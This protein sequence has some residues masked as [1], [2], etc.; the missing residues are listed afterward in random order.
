MSLD[1]FRPR[2]R[3]P[4]YIYLG[5]AITLVLIGLIMISS[6]SVVIAVET[7]NQTY[8]FVM[9][10]LIAIGV[11][12]VGAILASRISYQRWHQLTLPF[13]IGSLILVLLLLVPGLGKET[14]GAVRWIN[15][16]LFQLQP[17]ELLKISTI[18]YVSAWLERRINVIRQFDTLLGFA[19]F[20]MPIVIVMMIQ[21]DLGTLLI[22]LLTVGVMYF[23]AGAS[24]TQIVTGSVVGLCLVGMLIIIEPYRLERL[25]TFRN[26]GSD[27]LGAGYHINQAN[28]AIGSG[29]W[30]GRGF[31]QSIQKY[32]YLPEPQTDSIFAITV[33]EL[34]FLRSTLILVIIGAFSY[35][36]YQIAH[37]AGETFARFLAFGLTSMFLLQSIINLAAILGIVP[38]TGVP[39][40]FISYGGTSLVVSLLAVGIMVSISRNHYV[41][42]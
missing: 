25:A 3:S 9:R 23:I 32:L 39:L 21:R 22:I 12:V 41:A 37:R 24:T 5:L 35:R 27:T 1:R 19:V 15:L 4:D 30:F 2:K 33:E 28:L 40:P 16:G 8:G 11:G 26:N 42:N 17:S 14:K 18:L 31:G 36:G 29:G 6:S 34:G 38:L 7:Y 10:Q 20:L 13:F